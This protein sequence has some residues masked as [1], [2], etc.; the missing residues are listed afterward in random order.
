MGY[1]IKTICQPLSSAEAPLITSNDKIN[2]INAEINS[3]TYAEFRAI[4]NVWFLF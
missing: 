4:P 1:I 2:E 3:L